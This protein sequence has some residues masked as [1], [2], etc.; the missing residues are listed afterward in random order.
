MA[1]ENFMKKK[2]DERVDDLRP[3]YD[4]STLTGGVRGKYLRRY[5]AG[6]N[7]V[8]LTPEVAEAFPDDESVNEALRLLMKVAKKRSPQQSSSKRS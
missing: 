2:I 1:R 7:L 3:E 6:T 8:L 5:R 4:P